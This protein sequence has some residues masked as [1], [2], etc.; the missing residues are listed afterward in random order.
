MERSTELLIVV[1]QLV[2][3]AN[4]ECVSNITGL[5]INCLNP[6][7]INA[8][9]L[10]QRFADVLVLCCVGCS[11]RI[12]TSSQSMTAVALNCFKAESAVC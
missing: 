2:M 5:N 3:K 12:S 9:Y 4:A 1:C 7:A 6:P 11:V 10:F 8:R